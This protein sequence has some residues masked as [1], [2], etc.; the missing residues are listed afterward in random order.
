MGQTENTL[1]AL[2]RDKY[3]CQ[4]HLFYHAAIRPTYTG[5]H[6]LGRSK[7]DRVEDIIAL[8]S[9]CH[10]RAHNREITREELYGILSQD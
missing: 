7:S 3:F 1:R 9:E 6:I 8:C 10:T 4:Y 5:H 2:Q